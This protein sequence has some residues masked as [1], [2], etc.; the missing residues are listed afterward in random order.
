MALG[1]SREYLGR[2][3]TGLASLALALACAL[4]TALPAS[5]AAPRQGPKNDAAF[6]KGPSPLTGKKHGDL[7]W[8]RRISAKA[9][10]SASGRN[11]L[12]L[13]RSTSLAGKSVPVSG[14]VMLPKG[15]PP[16]A[17]WPV[18]TFA[19]GTTGI[20]DECAPSKRPLTGDDY[21][22][23]HVDP[24]FS[25][26][27]K[28]GYVVAHTDYEGLGTPGVHPYLIG[29]SAAR[30]VLDIVR[31]T[32]QLDKRVGKRVL[33]S[34]HSQGG[35]AAIW[36]GSE[37]ASWTPELNVVGTQA[38]APA[39]HVSTLVR[40]ASAITAKGGLAPEAALFLRSLDVTFPNAMIQAGLSEAALELYPQ[41]LDRCLDELF[42]LDSFG[43]L[44][45]AEMLNPDVPTEPVALLTEKHVDL[46]KLK[47][48]G[49]ILLLQGGK[50]TTVPQP[51]SD[52]LADE[53]RA[54]GGKLVYKV[55]KRADHSSVMIAGRRDALSHARQRL[56]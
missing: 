7:I 43:G 3:R 10:A 17:G 13:Y 23:K 36:A 55:Y 39:S 51:L 8:T 49:G 24:L 50:D 27:L 26:W 30:G 12:V 28:A 20:A 2:M 16:K 56:R 22:K 5:A 19:H 42:A 35:H 14:V 41:T 44:S 40:A 29:K 6:Y 21:G 11:M 34:G 46:T 45:V 32:R 47:F 37:A 25:G 53:T 31:A 1:L 38:F 18:V 4:I 33:I 52:A 54:A 15:D 48:R 9:G